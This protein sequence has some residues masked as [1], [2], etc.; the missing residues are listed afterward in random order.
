MKSHHAKFCDRET[1]HGPMPFCANILRAAKKNTHFRTTFWTGTHLQMTLMCIP[2][3]EDIGLEIHPDTDQ[4]IRV[5]AGRA[6]VRMGSCERNLDRQCV[7]QTGDA[8]FVPC[9]TWHNIINIGSCPL[10][11]SSVY[12]PPHHPHGTVHH[13]KADAAE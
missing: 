8:V 4:Y 7:L 6:V 1:D 5:E 10:K 9:G 12:A 13:T 11:L 2:V 3:R